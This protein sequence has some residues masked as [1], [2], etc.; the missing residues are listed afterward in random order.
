MKQIKDPVHGYINIEDKYFS[1]IIDTR[2][3]QRLRD[4]KQLSATYMVYPSANHTRF[5]HSL[6]VY[7]LAKRAFENITNEEFRTNIETEKIKRTLLC[8]ALLHDI[9]HPPFSHIAEKLLDKNELKSKLDDLGL[10]KRMDDAGIGSILTDTHPLDNKGEHELL[11]CIITLKYYKSV[12]EDLDVDPYEVAAYILGYSIEAQENGKWQHRIA[13]HVLSSTMDVDRLDYVSRDNYM[14][15]ADVANLDVERLVSSYKVC[16]DPADDTYKL[17]F[18]EKALSTVSN[19]LDGR[20][21]VYMWVTQHHKSVYANA[22]LRELLQELDEHQDGEI[23]TSGMILDEYID[24]SYVRTQ[25]RKARKNVSSDSRLAELYDRFVERNVLGSC[26][27]HKLAY[28]NN[29]KIE[30]REHF[31]DQLGN[32]KDQLEEKI[33]DAIDIDD[34]LVWVEESYVPNYKPAD[35]R[36]VQIAYQSEVQDVSEIGL[37]QEDDYTGPTPYIFAPKNKREEILDLLNEAPN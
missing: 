22:L 13:S 26:W 15:G 14:T 9:G 16:K 19:Y 24:D 25:L 32:N 3:F 20:L 33:A 5:E 36:D 28:I 2:P 17:T 21:A 7:W 4:L 6:G 23:F 8:A 35:L 31:E 12:L 27:K 29:L 10:K 34:K 30:A 18:S 1:K 11:S 37:Y